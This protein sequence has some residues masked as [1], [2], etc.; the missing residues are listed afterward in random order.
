MSEILKQ[1]HSLQ[2]Y[3]VFATRLINSFIKRGNHSFQVTDEMIGYVTNRLIKAESRYEYDKVKEDKRKKLTPEECRKFYLRMNGIYGIKAYID[4]V[5][6]KK[7]KRVLSTDIPV[8]IDIDRQ[9]NDLMSE[10]YY[11][12]VDCDVEDRL[13]STEE[14]EEDRRTLKILMAS[15]TD[16]QKH[17]VQQH[18]FH[19]KT[20]EQIG[21]ESNPPTSPQAVSFAYHNALRKMRSLVKNKV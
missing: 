13:I 5:Y 7:K 11:E 3:V 1:Y 14:F 21:R 2:Y 20:F 10:L 15:L 16:K 9:N 12:L 19:N 8:H 6:K 17:A 18:I 4:D